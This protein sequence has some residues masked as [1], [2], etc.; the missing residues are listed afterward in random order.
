MKFSVRVLPLPCTL[1][2]MEK[3]LLLLPAFLILPS[4]LAFSPKATAVSAGS[5]PT[6]GSLP[7]TNITLKDNTDTEIRAYYEDLVD[8]PSSE[9]TG[10]N[11]L[12]NLKPILQNFTYYSYDAVWK[13]YEI[14]DREW[15]LSPATGDTHSTTSYNA[16]TQT[17]SKYVY[18]ESNSSGGNNPYV[19]TLYRN[20]DEYGVTVESGRIREWGDH[21]Q[22]GGTNREHVWC[23]SRGFK[24][25]SGASGP[26]GTDIHHLISGDGYV[27]GTP[28]N[29]NPY[30]FVKNVTI[31]D[32]K[33]SYIAGNV[34]GTAVNAS[35]QDE[36]AIVFEPQDSDKGDIARACFYMVACYNNYSGEGGIT[37][38]NPNLMM[39][40]YATD[41]GTSVIS[42]DDSP[43]GMGILRDL[44]AWHKLDPVDEYEIH[45]NNLI[46]NNYQHNR[47]PFIDFP[48][49][50][51]YIWGT[52]ELNTTT[53]AVT[54]DATPTGSANV[55]IDVINGYKEPEPSSSSS[56]SSSSE[57]PI[58]DDTTWTYASEI[59]DGDEVAFIV[60]SAN[61]GAGSL[62]GNYLQVVSVDMDDKMFSSFTGQAFTTSKVSDGVFRFINSAG[63]YLSYGTSSTYIT[64]SD[65]IASDSKSDW[66]ITCDANGWYIANANSSRYLG[67]NS[68]GRVAAYSSA[69]DNLKTYPPV[70]IYRKGTYAS[71][72]GYAKRLLNEWTA[73]CYDAGGY[74]PT[75]M[76]WA[77]AKSVFNLLS[78]QVQGYLKANANFGYIHEAIAR[79]DQIVNKYADEV[80][81]D[82][83]NREEPDSHYAHNVAKRKEATTGFILIAVAST[84][85]LVGIGL[86]LHSSKRRHG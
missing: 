42:G 80:F 82:F 8:L 52:T 67:Y 69:G 31:D 4:A 58:I 14:T 10:T 73:G 83:M 7:S 75:K 40:D 68:T 39:C 57:A 47:N 71:A 84:A 23:Q 77:E 16:A 66:N 76:K 79:Y 28:H 34:A 38:F 19:H 12:K 18:G 25:S 81:E 13:I 51:D 15:S 27:N 11:L 45:R 64:L 85:L 5:G 20:R 65:S 30:G 78:T 37:Q 46:Y 22:N 1:M 86:C 50:V 49:W 3:A 29:N 62:N 36:S 70:S 33:Y 72:S 21:T 48:E 56:S 63:K 17:Y 43:V 74:D 9:L 44:L 53:K 6:S 26:A 55:E 61:K 24:A 32:T 60:E 54:Y 35:A 41:S 59:Q 2:T